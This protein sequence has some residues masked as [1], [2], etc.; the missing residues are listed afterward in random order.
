MKKLLLAMGCFAAM[1]AISS[2]TADSIEDTKSSSNQTAT[3]T[4][5]EVIVPPGIDDTNPPKP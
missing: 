4:T 1:I 3:P 5:T 2:C